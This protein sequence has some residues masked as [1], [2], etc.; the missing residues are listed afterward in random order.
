MF[1]EYSS[2]SAIFTS[3]T[4]LPFTRCILQDAVTLSGI[5][6][7]SVRGV[8]LFVDSC[9]F[10]FVPTYLV[11]IP[12]P[13]DVYTFASIDDLLQLL[14]IAGTGSTSRY[15]FPSWKVIIYYIHYYEYCEPQIG[16]CG[17]S[18]CL[19]V[20]PVYTDTTDSRPHTWERVKHK[21]VFYRFIASVGYPVT[22]DPLHYH[23]VYRV[24]CSRINAFYFF[25]TK[26]LDLQL[27]TASAYNSPATAAHTVFT[28]L[29][30]V[31]PFNMD[32]AT[33]NATGIQSA[34]HRASALH[35]PPHRFTSSRQKKLQFAFVFGEYLFID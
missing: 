27:N 7:E 13:I 32:I 12:R 25:Y 24:F 1:P 34:F 18:S 21:R 31:H 35:V 17:V 30:F 23:V 26:L 19:Q 14:L 33:A 3:V 2:V 11:E 22:S 16:L 8:H 29:P 20:Y 15:C 10:Q 28:A 4:N 9:V 6:T 5:T